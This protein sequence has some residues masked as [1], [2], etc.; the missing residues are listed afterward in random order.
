DPVPTQQP[1]GRSSCGR[2]ALQ[3]QAVV[4]REIRGLARYAVFLE[5]RR[6]SA[7]HEMKWSNL[8]NDHGRI[9]HLARTYSDVVAFRDHVADC[10]VQVQFDVDLRIAA[11][12]GGEQRQYVSSTEWR[13]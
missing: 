9:P 8:A 7:H 13:N 4:A 10:V 1:V 3:P 5:V 11:A 6:R 2:A 12:E